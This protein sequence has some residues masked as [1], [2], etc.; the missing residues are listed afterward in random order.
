MKNSYRSLL[1]TTIGLL[2]L[3]ILVPLQAA[4]ADPDSTFGGT[5]KVTGGFGADNQ[6]NAIATQS[7]G[8]IVAVGRRYGTSSFAVYRYNTN[9]SLDTSFYGGGTTSA[10]SFSGA[11]RAVKIQSDDK[12]VVAGT[13][14][15][16]GVVVRLNADGSPDS[17]FGTGGIVSTLDEA[18]A[19]AIQKVTKPDMTMEERI[20][21]AGANQQLIFPTGSGSVI[22]VARLNTNGSPDTG[23]ANGTGV[24]ETQIGQVASAHAVVIAGSTIVVAGRGNGDSFNPGY[25]T[26]ARY[27]EEGSLDASFNNGAGY[28]VTTAGSGGSTANAVAIQP[29]R[30]GQGE[31]PIVVAGISGLAGCIDC[32]DFTVVRYHTDGTRDTTFATDGILVSDVS[33]GHADSLRSLLIQN[34]GTQINPAYKIVVG[35]LASFAGRSAFVVARFTS[36]GA[37]DT[38]FDGGGVNGLTTASFSG[39][40]ACNALAFSAGKILGAGFTTVN[41]DRHFAL[42]RYN[43]NG[44]PDIAFDGDG[45]RT[46]DV[47]A[48]YNAARAVALQSDGKIVVA[49]FLSTSSNS[50]AGRTGIMRWNSDGTPDPAFGGIGGPGDGNLSASFAGPLNGVAVRSDG[51]ILAAGSSA[52]HLFLMRVSPDSASVSGRPL[53]EVTATTAAKAVAIQPD[54]KAVAVGYVLDAS[55]NYD[56]LV[57]RFNQDMSLDGSFGGGT[58]FVMTDLGTSLDIANSVAI[59]ADEK[60]V[61]AGRTADAFAVVR[62]NPDGMRD[63][64][65]DTDGIVTTFPNPIAGG[66]NE[67]KSVAI[68]ADGKIVVTGDANLFA[69]VRYNMD[70]SLDHSFSGDGIVTTGVGSNSGGEAVAIQADGKILVAGHGSGD[71]AVVRYKSD[72]SLDTSFTGTGKAFVDFAGNPSDRAYAIALD[73]SGRAVVVG[74]VG[75]LFGIA[76]IVNPPVDPTPTPT[77]TA[78]PTHTPTPSATPPHTPTPTATPPHSP[79]PTATP[80]HSPTPTATPAHSPTPT[81]TPTVAPGTLRNISTRVRVLGGDNVLIAGMIATGNVTKKVIIRAIGPTLSDF[82]VPDA[83]ADPTLE[84]FQGDTSLASNDNWRNSSQQAQIQNSSLAPSKDAE[85]AIIATLTPGQSYT[86]VIRGK[87]GG[88]GVGLVE[89]YDIDPAVGSKLA[90]ISTRGFVGVDD[91]VMIAGVTVGPENGSTVKVLVRALGP[92]L[93]DLGVPGALANPTL[94]LV[95]SN[96]TVIRSN[97]DWKTSQQAAIA[98][99]GLAPSHDKEAALIQTIPPGQYTAIVRGVG[100]TTGAGLVE[101]YNIQ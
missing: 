37:F 36:G 67:G 100:R 58:G 3:R 87:N 39:S 45:I 86:A 19:V 53:T 22:A 32:G 71:F 54:G 27:S 30:P 55:N 49:G 10:V 64:S 16:G 13:D 29:A 69:T 75:R 84:L 80:G 51:F 40:A 57:A 33:G 72:G 50:A 12:I 82:G 47:G 97:D 4:A 43:S 77:A 1:G 56:F 26:V 65:F 70:G 11:A 95:S 31:N 63:M 66:L 76:R 81:A 8:K 99:A 101:L 52:N 21:V 14:V 78:T 25:I 18:N 79:T 74:D 48:G 42:V 94:D 92:T 23:F 62:Y 93:G 91:N 24:V 68:Q 96:G 90:N 2:F 7:G 35:G 59:Q 41:G 9:G 88:T 44:S 85:A 60:I 73:S 89:V 6:V 38:S 83:L 5:G 98:A 46:D 20:V 17:G 61:V 34:T 28:V 15:N